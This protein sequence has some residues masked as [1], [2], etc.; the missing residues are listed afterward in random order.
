MHFLKTGHTYCRF[1]CTFFQQNYRTSSSTA[2]GRK[3]EDTAEIQTNFV[4]LFQTQR[5]ASWHCHITCRFR[6]LF[7]IRCHQAWSLS[8]GPSHRRQRAARRK[9]K[10]LGT[11]RSVGP[12][13][14]TR[15]STSWT[16]RTAPSWASSGSWRP[17]GRSPTRARRAARCTSTGATYSAT[18]S[19]S[20]AA[21]APSS[22][23]PSASRRTSD[24]ST[25]GATAS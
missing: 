19:T 10:R 24:R 17:A 12:S 16:S 23:A 13:M 15:T 20:A 14:R 2:F 5:T 11:R 6:C 22:S 8:P 25:S 3:E 7:R 9:L 1:D 21:A 18:S 4:F